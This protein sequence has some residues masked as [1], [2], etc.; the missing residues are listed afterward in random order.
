M[1]GVRGDGGE[2]SML[3]ATGPE[4]RG[5][6]ETSPVAL[7]ARVA[8]IH[9]RH[10][11]NVVMRNSI[12]DYSTLDAYVLCTSTRQTIQFGTA[13]V[14]INLPWSFFRA[15]SRA[16][17]SR[18]LVTCRAFRHIKYADRSH[19]GHEMP[20]SPVDFI[21]P[22]SFSEDHEV[23]MLWRVVGEGPLEPYPDI[24]VPETKRFCERIA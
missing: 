12:A 24:E 11:T 18:F 20:P 15:V 23:R 13:C 14:R 17:S 3:Y 9:F 4:V 5:T 19:E 1:E 8:G 10:S 21:K 22:A 2:G 6:P 7:V 16:I